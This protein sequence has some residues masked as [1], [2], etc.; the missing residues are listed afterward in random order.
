M[1]ALDGAVEVLA[2]RALKR[3]QDGPNP[4]RGNPAKWLDAVKTGIRRDYGPALE[5]VLAAQPGISAAELAEAVCPTPKP[6]VQH[7]PVTR[8]E[9]QLAR[10]SARAIAL[11][12]LD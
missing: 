12:R 2:G 4:V 1:G 9:D 7:G 3:R 5:A 10:S 8:T 11:A 6:P